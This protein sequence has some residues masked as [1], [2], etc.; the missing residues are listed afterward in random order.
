[1]SILD[2]INMN[3][4]TRA[5]GALEVPV[6]LSVRG[7]LLVVVGRRARVGCRVGS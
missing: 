6:V 5:K 2:G 3:K 1:L 7:R 4:D